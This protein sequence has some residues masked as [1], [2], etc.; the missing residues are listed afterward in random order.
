[1]DGE[2]WGDD[3]ESMRIYDPVGQ[4]S[5]KPIEQI[6]IAPALE[7]ELLNQSVEQAS[8]LDYL[9]PQTVV[10]FDDLLALEDRY[11]SLISL[12]AHNKFFSSIEDF[13]NQLAPFQKLFWSQKP[14]E[15][16]SEVRQIDAKSQGYYSQQTP[17]HHLHF[18]LQ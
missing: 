18:H 2:F 1:M 17:F 11:A 10:I 12:G 8:I 3:L 5:V 16:L 15:E 9:G 7:L 4:K 13:L 14:I 6:D